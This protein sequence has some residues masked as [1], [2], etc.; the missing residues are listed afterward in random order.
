[1]RARA[2]AARLARVLASPQSEARPLPG[3][4]PCAFDAPGRRPTRA[5]SLASCSSRESPP[6]RTGSAEFLHRLVSQA[7]SSRLRRCIQCGTCSAS[8]PSSHVMDLS[9]RQMLASLNA[10]MPDRVLA[11]KAPWLCASC[12]LCT[13]RCPSERPGDG[14]DVRAQARGR[15]RRMD[16]PARHDDGEGLRPHRRP[17]RPQLRG[18]AALPLLPAARA[19][20]APCPPCRSLCASCANAASRCA[21]RGSR[22][23]PASRECSP[24][25]AS[26]EQCHERH[27]R[28]HLLSR[29]AARRAVTRPTTSPPATSHV[30]SVSRWSS[31]T[32][33]TAAAP[34]PTSPS[35]TS[36]Q[37][38]SR[39][40][41]S[42]WP[43]CTAATSSRCAAAAT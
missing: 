20:T 41:T 17:A 2:V 43:K 22:A 29:A 9:P 33:G 3:P 38:C 16:R 36:P 7:E 23:T 13:V 37:P 11:S 18:P 6:L 25:H 21:A 28:L 15:Q 10:G 32:T 19:C 1:M 12:Y 27:S 31:S 39:R 30:C 34:R 42:P 4:S 8:C 5:R 14:R 35:T 40:A 24:R 26:R